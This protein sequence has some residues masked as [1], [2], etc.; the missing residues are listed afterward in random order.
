MEGSDFLFLVLIPTLIIIA[1][2]RQMRH[3]KKG[4]IVFLILLISLIVANIIHISI[5]ETNSSTSKA[6]NFKRGFF[7]Y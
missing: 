1:S 6:V 3:T 5:L 4:K 2:Y 7:T